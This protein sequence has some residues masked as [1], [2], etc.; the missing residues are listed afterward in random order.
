MA[1]SFI[2]GLTEKTIWLDGDWIVFQPDAEAEVAY[3]I[4]RSNL[5]FVLQSLFDANTILIA[6]DDDTPISITIPEETMIGRLTGEAIKALSISEIRTLAAVTNTLEKVLT[7]DQTIASAVGFK[8]GVN[9]NNDA[10][11]TKTFTATPTFDF[12]I[13]GNDQ[14]MTLTGNVTS[15]ATSNEVGSANY[16][17]YLINDGTPGRTVAAPTGWTADPSSET[18][19]T[20]A[21]AINLYQ[22]YTLPDGSKYFNLHIVKQ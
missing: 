6:T 18:H 3:R 17:V 9:A 11:A 13:D 7:P 12:K 4:K 10:N 8:R 16:K 21:N 14:Q 20:A 19:T 22:F 1:D 5:K 15:F 2:K